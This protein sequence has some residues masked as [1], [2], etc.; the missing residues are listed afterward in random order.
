VVSKIRALVDVA[1]WYRVA[2][3]TV[4][5]AANGVGHEICAYRFPYRDATGLTA[6]NESMLDVSIMTTGDSPHIFKDKK[7][8]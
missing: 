4:N 7:F 1:L 2:Q 6:L 8:N 3:H 5:V